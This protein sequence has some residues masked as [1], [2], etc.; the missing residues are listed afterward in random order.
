LP[1]Q[2]T[3]HATHF[4]VKCEALSILARRQKVKK[5]ELPKKSVS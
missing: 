3:L 1:N 4:F 5:S 2:V